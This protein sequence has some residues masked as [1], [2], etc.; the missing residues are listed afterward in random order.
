MHGPVRTA[1]LSSHC[2]CH[3]L[4]H[5]DAEWES[6][7]QLAASSLFHTNEACS[8]GSWGFHFDFQDLQIALYSTLFAR[9]YPEFSSFALIL[10]YGKKPQQRS[11]VFHGLWLSTSSYFAGFVLLMQS[12]LWLPIHASTAPGSDCSNSNKIWG[13]GELSIY[14]GYNLWIEGG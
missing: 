5:C 11:M 12:Q 4:P 6:C 13:W 3:P 8:T 2:T 7:P 10:L 1:S 14:Q 9:N